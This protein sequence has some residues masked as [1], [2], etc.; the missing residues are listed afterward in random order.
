MSEREKKLVILFS[1]GIFLVLNYFGYK[2]YLDQKDRTLRDLRKAQTEL[3]KA[4]DYQAQSSTVVDEMQW[5]DEHLPQPKAGQTV[6]SELMNYVENQAASNGLTVKRRKQG[7]VVEGTRFNRAKAEFVVNGMEENL[8]R[9]LDRLQ[10]PDQLR[11]VTHLQLF[12]QRDDDTKIECTVTVDQWYIPTD[13]SPVPDAGPAVE[14]PQDAAPEPA[15]AELPPG[16]ENPPV[17]A[18]DSPTPPPEDPPKTD[19]Q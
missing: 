8:Y 7:Q 11:A 4:K 1:V 18:A 5:L 6:S 15:P 3:A 13:G 12:P 19:G 10:A 14:T 17:P 9:W 16:L 2:F